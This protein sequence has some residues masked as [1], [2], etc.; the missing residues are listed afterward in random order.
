MDYTEQ[1]KTLS[2]IA[3]QAWRARLLITI[4]MCIAICAG[5][6]LQTTAIRHYKSTMIVAPANP[7]NGAEA[8]SLLADD[9]LFALRYIMQRVGAGNSSDFTRFENTYDGASVAEALLED[10]KIVSGLMMDRAF[11]FQKPETQ[12]N[13]ALLAKYISERARFEPLGAT[14]LRRIVYSH[15]NKAFAQYFLHKLHKITDNMIRTKIRTDSSQRIDYLEKTIRESRN[16]DHKR[17]LTTLLM[18]QERLKMLVSLD[19]P[20]AATIIE[21]PST[22]AKPSWPPLALMWSV[23]LFASAVLGFC[24]HQIWVATPAEIENKR[25]QKTWVKPTARNENRAL[26]SE[27]TENLPEDKQK[28]A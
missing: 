14:S 20:Y 1:P 16:P 10:E 24:T 18:E 22:Q 23:L 26:T 12:W 19:I 2:D 27:N 17:A 4:F 8:S 25:Y 13:T 15:Q 9:N 28:S 21:P 11:T 7:M 5:V 3:A 6:A